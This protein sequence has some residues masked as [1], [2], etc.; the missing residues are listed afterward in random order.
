MAPSRGS[1]R[2][3]QG[4]EDAITRASMLPASVPKISVRT[5][6]PVDLT[7]Y[8]ESRQLR[9]ARHAEIYFEM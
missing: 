7:N 8:C 1:A 6:A 2:S 3:A 4:R 9:V 5:N